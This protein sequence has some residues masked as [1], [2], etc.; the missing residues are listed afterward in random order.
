MKQ[1]PNII[2]FSR[3]V[4][5]G[6]IAWLAFERWAGAATITFV[7]SVIAALSDWLDGYV[8]RKWNL[9]SDFGKLMDALVD[10]IMVV[11][12]FLVLVWAGILTRDH[13]LLAIL[14]WVIIVATVLRDVIITGMRMMAARRGIVLAADKIGKRKTI[15][16]ITSICVLFFVPVVVYDMG[17]LGVYQTALADFVWLNGLLYF[18]LG[19]ILTIYSGALYV[20]RYL[21]HVSGPIPP[22]GAR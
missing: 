6:V 15:W 10:K 13:H 17:F 20:I 5:L 8:A 14:A 2:T 12:L 1:L 4:F 19:G 16:Q 22:S 18:L 7:L 11:G 9:I 21:P 3:I